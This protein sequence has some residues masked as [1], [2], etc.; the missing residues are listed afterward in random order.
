MNKA[1]GKRWDSKQLEWI[2]DN[3]EEDES[4]LKDVPDD[5]SDVLKASEEEAA[6]EVDNTSSV[7][8]EVEYYDALGVE[9]HADEKKIKRAYFVNAR[10]WHPDRNDSSEAKEKF[11]A[12]GE[13]Y[14]VLSDPNLRAAY[15]KEGKGGLSGDKTNLS[16]GNLDPALV[17]AF[18]FG[19]D[20]FNDVI[21][22]LQVV[23]QTMAGDS[24]DKHIGEKELLELERRRVIR[25]AIKLRARV[26]VFVEG[27][28]D[29]AREAW[30][31]EAST[32]VE[33]RYGEEILNTV[34]ATYRL[35]AT[36]VEGSWTEGMDAQIS[37]H[38]MKFE[39]A[40]K[41]VKSAQEMQGAEDGEEQLPVYIE[42]LWNVTVVDITSTIREVVMKVLSDKS[43]ENDVRKKRAK[44]IM[45]LGRIFED[46]KSAKIKDSK[47]ANARES[48]QS[49]ASAA[50]EWTLKKSHKEEKASTKDV[51]TR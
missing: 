36:Q 15:D 40:K 44:A 33:C 13:A 51:Q 21:G 43:V 6:T 20:S 41:A 17:F 37:E 35:V 26:Q 1:Q 24:K 34:G 39:A 12:I 38:E 29:A 47:E 3:I 31:E 50:M 46:E 45:T 18:L 14:Q 8:K 49:A 4:T 32:L 10:K 7:V 30:K 2:I 19:S 23:T 9:T 28:E 11:Q 27:Q 48:Y 16:A 25:L 5:D 22:R 42:T